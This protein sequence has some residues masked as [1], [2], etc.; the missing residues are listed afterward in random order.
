[1]SLFGSDDHPP[2]ARS[3]LFG[4]DDDDDDAGHSSPPH[5]V[6]GVRSSLFDDGLATSDPWTFTPR[7][8]RSGS[9]TDMVKS[10]MRGA[11]VPN[12]Y[13]SLY[14]TLAEETGGVTVGRLETLLEASR[15]REGFWER[16]LELVAGRNRKDGTGVGRE[17]FN[18]FLALVGLAEE[19]EE[20][21]GF[22]AVDDRKRSSSSRS[23]YFCL[24]SRV[25]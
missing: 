25:L 9:T 17:A 4:A 24:S 7:A 11:A 10:V 22:D 1:M 18:V 3:S 20:D 15:V 2:R 16:I 14:D 5:A 21:L 8:K 23:F 19:G 12:E 6:A 13:M